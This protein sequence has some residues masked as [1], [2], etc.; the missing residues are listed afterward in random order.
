MNKVCLT[1]FSSN[2]T[3]L[4]NQDIIFSFF[5][6]FKCYIKAAAL[7]EYLVK[8]HCFHNGNKR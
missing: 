5:R 1:L 3:S 8:N 2:K 7:L 4:N 6:H